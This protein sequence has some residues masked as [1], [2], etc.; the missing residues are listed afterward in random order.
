MRKLLSRLFFHL[1]FW[2]KTIRRFFW[3]LLRGKKLVVDSIE[4]DRAFYFEGGNVVLEWKVQNAWLIT[5]NHPGGY[6]HS[7][8]MT[9]F[10]ASPGME[11]IRITVRG[12]GKKV[13]REFEVRVKPFQ[14]HPPATRIYRAEPR[15]AAIHAGPRLTPR[16]RAISHQQLSLKAEFALLPTLPSH[17]SPTARHLLALRQCQDREAFA[18]LD[19]ELRKEYSSSPDTTQP[20]SDSDGTQ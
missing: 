10:T 20:F 17:A 8:D 14:K 18:R 1:F 5:V 7:T 9:W 6:Y 2:L 15:T 12:I 11:P 13:R 4:I 19:A 3:L 16:A